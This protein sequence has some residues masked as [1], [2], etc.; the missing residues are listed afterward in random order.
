MQKNLR[1][2]VGSGNSQE[3]LLPLAFIHILY[4]D[5]RVRVRGVRVRVRV[6]V[7]VR[8]RFRFR[9]RAVSATP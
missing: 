3:L 5:V 7:R 4:D 6:K 9:V 8:V 2:F 1:V